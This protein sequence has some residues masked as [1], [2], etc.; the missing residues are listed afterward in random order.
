MTNSTNNSEAMPMEICESDIDS[1]R[2]RSLIWKTYGNITG[3]DTESAEKNEGQSPWEKA[4]PDRAKHQGQML[5]KIR[6]P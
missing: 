2:M 3:L 4:K 5:E 1:G 6:R